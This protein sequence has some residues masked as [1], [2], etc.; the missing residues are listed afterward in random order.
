MLR[1]DIVSVERANNDVVTGVG[2]TLRFRVANEYICEAQSIFNSR[3]GDFTRPAAIVIPDDILPPPI[4]T[5][6]SMQFDGINESLIS[7]NSS[8]FD[9]E[10]TQRFSVA[11]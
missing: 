9:I 7:P 4:V 1:G 2:I 8:V 11:S 5:R 3:C 10:T 6:Y